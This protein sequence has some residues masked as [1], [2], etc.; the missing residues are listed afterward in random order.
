MKSVLDNS[1]STEHRPQDSGRA[2]S[3]EGVSMSA[4]LDALLRGSE[5]SIAPSLGTT[6]DTADVGIPDSTQ[7]E[8]FLHG[9]VHNDDSGPPHTDGHVDTGPDPHDDGY[10]DH[11]EQSQ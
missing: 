1:I 8:I 6:E 5:A 4:Y 9:D 11:G 7:P 3:G 2:A 10:I